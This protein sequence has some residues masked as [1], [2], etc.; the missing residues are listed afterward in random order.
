MEFHSN[1]VCAVVYNE[2]LY[3]FYRSSAGSVSMC[4]FYPE[5][6]TK[7]VYETPLNYECYA[8]SVQCAGTTII[9]YTWYINFISCTL[10]YQ[11]I[12]CVCVCVCVH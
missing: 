2:N 1:E 10:L 7:R 11:V 9:L 12:L 8:D 3:S 4:S 5:F 6:H